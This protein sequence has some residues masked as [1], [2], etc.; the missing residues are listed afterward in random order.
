[1]LSDRE[2]YAVIFRAK[3]MD[4]AKERNKRSGS[5]GENI[6]GKN[7]GIFFTWVEISNSPLFQVACW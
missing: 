1:M 4:K 5:K 7:T 3:E 6:G 2:I